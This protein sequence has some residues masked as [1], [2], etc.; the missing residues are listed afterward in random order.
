MSPGVNV[1]ANVVAVGEDLT[2]EQISYL[3]SHLESLSDATQS[4]TDAC[5]AAFR[6]FYQTYGPIICRMTIRFGLSI[7]EAEECTQETWI[8][9][10]KSLPRFEARPEI[11]RFETWLFAVVRSQVAQHRRRQRRSTHES[12]ENPVTA[13]QV[14]DVTD[15]WDPPDDP[16]QLVAEAITLL[17]PDLSEQSQQ[18]LRMK[19]REDK[20][21]PEIAIQLSRSPH[22]I[23]VV[24]NRLNQ[25]LAALIKQ[26][27]L[28]DESPSISLQHGA[29][30]SAQ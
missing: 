16:C 9:L 22:Q 12:L 15:P 7:D 5:C 30:N 8:Q 4:H 18:I 27:A 19:W 29:K 21:I 3:K 26:R 10:I 11:C 6:G 2:V 28:N 14:H 17:N 20:S 24:L 13:G 25:R 23:S 1:Q